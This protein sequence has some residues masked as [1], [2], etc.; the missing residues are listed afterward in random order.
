M[1]HMM[2][3]GVPAVEPTA[4]S[5]AFSDAVSER[6]R[7]IEAQEEKLQRR[8]SPSVTTPCC[9]R[10]HRLLDEN[11]QKLAAMEDDLL[12][13]K[14]DVRLS[15]TAPKKSALTTQ[16]LMRAVLRKRALPAPPRYL[17]D[18]AATTRQ[19][20]WSCCGGKLRNRASACV[21]QTPNATSA[22]RRW[23]KQRRWWRQ[24]KR[25]R[26]GSCVT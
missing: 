19:S 18:C 22:P 14:R 4:G 16:T 13:L 1:L 5:K 17:P 21:R 7:H 26:R 3:E 6:E 10:R 9:S 15:G 11:K 8:V 12:K 25:P 20:R 23:R 2:T 24:R